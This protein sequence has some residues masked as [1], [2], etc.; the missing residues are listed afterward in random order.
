MHTH[1]RWVGDVHTHY[2]WVGDMHTHY[3]WVGDMHTKR[4]YPNAFSPP[5]VSVSKAVYT[6]EALIDLVAFA[7]SRGVR[8]MPEWDMPGH[9]SWGFGR[10]DLVTSACSDALDVTRPELCV[11]VG[12]FGFLLFSLFSLLCLFVWLF[13]PSHFAELGLHIT[14]HKKTIFEHT[15]AMFRHSIGVVHHYSSHCNI[16]VI[17]QTLHFPQF[18]FSSLIFQ[19]KLKLLFVAPQKKALI[20]HIPIIFLPGTF[21]SKHFSP[22]WGR[23]SPTTTSSWAA[24]S[25]PPRALTTRRLLLRG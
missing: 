4:R 6:P 11:V 1:Y 20:S 24:T 3:R 8:I 16:V 13:T 18:L 5:V 9:G 23:S 14:I 17:V 15:S 7:R 2:R 12:S 25:S 22:K 21:F 19:L 10:P